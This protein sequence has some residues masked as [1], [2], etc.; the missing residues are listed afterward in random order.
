[1]STFN[2][3]FNLRIRLEKKKVHT[4]NT[5]LPASEQIRV[6]ISKKSIG[7]SHKSRI[8]GC[9]IDIIQKHV[10]ADSSTTS[11]LAYDL[12]HFLNKNL[13]N[14]V[15]KVDERCLLLRQA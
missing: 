12:A 10:L 13:A 9:K 2:K 1:M 11:S 14:N 15:S 8:L 7:E 4:N 6:C 5:T 3:S